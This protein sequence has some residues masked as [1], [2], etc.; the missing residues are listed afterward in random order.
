MTQLGHRKLAQVRHLEMALDSR[1]LQLVQAVDWKSIAPDIAVSI[2]PVTP[3]SHSSP[4]TPDEPSGVS[5]WHCGQE[6]LSR[7]S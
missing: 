6:S 7:W 2:S 1:L 5:K 4:P 3:K